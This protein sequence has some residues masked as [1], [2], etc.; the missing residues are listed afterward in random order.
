MPS[1]IRRAVRAQDILATGEVRNPYTR[2]LIYRPQDRASE[3]R[4]QLIGFPSIQ[5]QQERAMDQIA[6][7]TIERFKKNRS[8]AA[9]EIALDLI[10]G[11]DVTQLIREANVA[12]YALDQ[13]TIRRTVR[14]LQRTA[15]ER[16]RRRTPRALRAS[17]DDLYE[18]T[19][20]VTGGL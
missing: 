18:T 15:A 7:R 12:G 16:R 14:E 10:A 6:S 2:K 11:K 19:G 13:R 5:M 4:K 9:K 20:S 3:A 8:E 17:L 1:A